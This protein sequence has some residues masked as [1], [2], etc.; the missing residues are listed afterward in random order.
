MQFHIKIMQSVLHDSQ[1][2]S[3][4]FYTVPVLLLEEIHMLIKII[5]ISFM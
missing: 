5:I 3:M 1:K 2:I 4:K